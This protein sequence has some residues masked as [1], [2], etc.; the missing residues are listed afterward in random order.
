MQLWI[1]GHK[2]IYWFSLICLEQFYGETKELKPLA[3][4]HMKDLGSQSFWSQSKL[5]ITL[6]PKRP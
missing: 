6:A 3:K 2:R 5:Q 1:L 4:N